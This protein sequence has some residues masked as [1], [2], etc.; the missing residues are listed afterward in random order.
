MAT[1]RRRGA[2][3][4][5]TAV[6]LV[7]LSAG[8][9]VAVS[10]ALGIRA[11][12]AEQMRPAPAHA[13][14]RTSFTAPPAFTSIQ[15]PDT[16]RMQLALDELDT[17]L[18]DA[19]NT[20]GEASLEV[21][22]TGTAADD[23]YT[24]TGTPD[25]LRIEAAGES[26]AARGVYDLAAAIRAD[27]DI[28]AHL[29]ET[30]TSALPLRM[31]DLGAVGVEA[32]P[33]QW[34]S[35]EDYS[36]VSR[37][38]ENAYLEEAPYID[39]TALADDYEQWDDYL[40]H[41]VGL[42]YNAVAW[43]GF[44]EYVDFATAEGEVYPEGDPHIARAAALRAA[45][46]P[47]WERAAEL[48]VKIYL[49]TDMLA[50][51]PQLADYLDARFGSPDTENPELWKV[52]TDALDELYAEVPAISGVL[53]RIGEGGSIYAEPGWDYYSALAVRSVDAVRT[54]L[55]AFTE[56]A[57]SSGREVIFRT[58]SVGIGDVGDMHTDADSY[59]A[60]LD[61]LDSPALIVSTKYTL[62]D[63]YSW[64]PLNAT[65]EVGEQRRIVEFQSRREFEGFGSF[66]NDLGPEFQWALQT[67]IAA[68]PNIEG[69]WTWTQDGGPWRAGPMTLYLTSGFWQLYELGT[70]Q[71]AALARDPGTDVADVTYAWARRYLASEP[72]TALAVVDAMA[73]SR[74]AIT[75]GLYLQGFA[76]NRVFA[77]G[78]EPPPQMWLFE[79]DI[80]TGD[81]AT[82]DTMYAIIGADRVEQTIRQGDDAVTAVHRMR[83]IVEGASGLGWRD[84][85]RQQLLDSLDYEASTLELLNAYRAAFLYQAE[86]HDTGSADAYAR[87][88][89]ARD[90]FAAASAE[91]LER[92]TGDLEHPAWNLTAAELGV[93]RADRDLAMAWIARALLALTLAWLLIG[94]FSARTR[95]VRRPGAAAARA[96][97][98]ASSR[99]WRAQESTLGLDDLDKALIVLVPGALL[100]G[101]R[102]VQTSFL[103]PAQLAITLGAWAVFVALLLLLVRGR[104]A[105]AALSAIGGVI[106]LRAVLLLFALAFT[107]PGGYWF[108]FWTDPV[109]RTVY[110]SLAFAAFLWTFVAA[111]WALAAR[112]GARRAT[113]VVLAAVGAGLAVPAAIVGVI[114]LEQALTVWNDQLGLLPWGLARI[115]GI[116]TYLEIPDATAWWAAAFGAVLLA[117]GLL[118]ALLRAPHTRRLS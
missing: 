65:L 39:D 32:D 107:G 69:V 25:A 28:R 98:I 10:D 77:V 60:V 95:L 105:W 24:L 19:E 37:A 9:A 27:H 61:G 67:L 12:P 92:Y 103:A 104:T 3:A 5:A 81:T 108:G 93:E 115:L 15:A 33:D 64:L 17:A 86:W 102:A 68:N 44:I 46:T 36:H 90:T 49:R 70:M 57:E 55:T 66:P 52:Y 20:E 22:I 59:R 72:G 1:A 34:A 7:A 75:Q 53:I 63:F 45:F 62:G 11:E 16:V 29:G 94:I 74:T 110:I 38:F 78:L 2:L 41:V 54:M 4:V 30:V 43:P 76:E 26:G 6:V 106:V 23:T 118:L 21:V 100:V 117:V 47:F 88:Q 82:L 101:T 56:Q 50:L 89:T 91:H 73:S 116:T 99:P 87:W 71:A 8:V 109:R 97:W 58:W 35:G 51:T 31:V 112:L 111:G 42:G 13:P 114:G 40:R 79:W 96:T 14:Q 18:A 48:G 83:E 85:A 113:G 80:L 84:G